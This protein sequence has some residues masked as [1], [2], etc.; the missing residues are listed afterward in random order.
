M[1]I[2]GHFLNVKSEY[3]HLIGWSNFI[4]QD[5]YAVPKDA[6]LT[7]CFPPT[8]G[9]T[10]SSQFFLEVG[11]AMEVRHPKFPCEIAP[12][13][14]SKVLNF[15]YFIAEVDTIKV[16]N[17]CKMCFHVASPYIFQCGFA[18]SNKIDF[19][20]TV[21]DANGVP[22]TWKTYYQQLRTIPLGLSVV[23][24]VRLFKRIP[25]KQSLLS[26]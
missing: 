23:L 5:L 8:K 1:I 2:S 10:C 16:K 13:L 26:N 15:G 7:S 3:V 12:A 24:N 18:L 4:G 20:E 22:S 11:M 6:E 19:M 17:A 9:S 21:A 25:Q 14:V